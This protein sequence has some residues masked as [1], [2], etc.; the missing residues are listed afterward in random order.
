MLEAPDVR[1][2]PFLLLEIR[3]FLF[4]FEKKWRNDENINVV[5]CNSFD[6]VRGWTC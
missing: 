5:Y 2:L 1:K 4:L 3:C 6:S